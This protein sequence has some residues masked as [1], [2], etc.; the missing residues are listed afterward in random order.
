MEP[1]KR[2]P[3]FSLLIAFGA[4]VVLL[5]PMA[6]YV[7]LRANEEGA[8]LRKPAPAVEDSEDKG[9]KPSPMRREFATAPEDM[10]KRAA[11]R[12]V[13]PP[14]TSAAKTTPPPPAQPFPS[15]SDVPVGMDKLKLLASFGRPN[16]VT[17]EVAEGRALETFRYL[18]PELG[19]ETTVYLRSGR[20]VG[21]ASNYY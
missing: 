7:M 8:F 12:P 17:T 5:T 13:P 21:T 4:A 11:A 10:P 6:V 9:Q 18:R 2:K 3:M 15:T 14:D 19:I 20:V 1:E 16:I